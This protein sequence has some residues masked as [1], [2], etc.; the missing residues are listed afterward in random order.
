[1]LLD[2]RAED[3]TR[4]ALEDTTH[5]LKLCYPSMAGGAAIVEFE[6]SSEPTPSWTPG[7][8][9]KSPFF[10]ANNNRLFAIS[11]R[12]RC[13]VRLEFAFDHF[14]P[15]SVFWRCLNRLNASPKQQLSWS[16]WAATDTR[17]FRASLP[18]SNVWVCFAYGSRSMIRELSRR[19]GRSLS[20]IMYD[21]NQLAFRRDEARG[22]EMV[23]NSYERIKTS[24]PV[25]NPALASDPVWA[26]SVQTSL[27][28]GRYV[29]ALPSRPGDP[30]PS[31]M[32]TADNLVLVDVSPLLL[33]VMDYLR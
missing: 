20:L 11:M 22:K 4:K 19:N 2:F 9:D 1:M 21:F 29:K 32:C 15:L 27:P 8:D 10:I 30:F 14:V 31:I 3:G 33:Y 18:A 25:P 24:G 7:P 23:P 6:V 16:D 12:V 5:S 26:E 13:N 17:L 28:C